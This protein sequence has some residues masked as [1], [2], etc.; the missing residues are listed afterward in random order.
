MITYWKK[1]FI[2]KVNYLYDPIKYI[3]KYKNN[4]KTLNL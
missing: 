1:K 4:L 2:E 3:F